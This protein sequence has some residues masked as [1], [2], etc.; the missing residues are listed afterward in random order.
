MRNLFLF[1]LVALTL[2]S[3]G[4]SETIVS[5]NSVSNTNVQLT[6]KNFVGIAPVYG[7]ATNTYYFGLGGLANTSLIETATNE[8]LSKAGLNG[9]SR[10]VINVSYDIHRSII[11]PIY[12]RKRITVSGYVIEFLK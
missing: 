8:M 5:N 10:V 12:Y 9:N 2:S 1:S 3:C 6:Q 7:E 11:Y 4:L